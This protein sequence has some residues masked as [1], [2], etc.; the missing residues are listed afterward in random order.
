[1]KTAAITTHE[2]DDDYQ[3]EK[4]NPKQQTEDINRFKRLK[5]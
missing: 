3:K 2:E 5:K 4:D 1:M